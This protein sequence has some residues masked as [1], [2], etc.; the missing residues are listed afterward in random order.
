MALVPAQT[1]KGQNQDIHSVGL[2]S[3]ILVRPDLNDESVYRLARAIH[4]GHEA[5]V[6]RLQQGRY[7]RAE[8]TLKYVPTEQ[9]HTGTVKYYKDIGLLPSLDRPGKSTP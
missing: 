7:T 9:L 1:Y 3:L 5:L 2:W 8:N 6:D 4:R